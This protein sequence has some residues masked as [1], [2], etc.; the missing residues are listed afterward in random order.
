MRDVNPP[1]DHS[2]IATA[3][4]LVAALLALAAVAYEYSLLKDLRALTDSKAAALAHSQETL[5][6]LD[7]ELQSGARQ[8]AATAQRTR[9]KQAAPNNRQAGAARARPSDRA[10]D[11]AREDAQLLL[12]SDPSIR[13]T[14]EKIAR[15]QYQAL[16][17]AFI[18]QQNLTAQQTDQL[19]NAAVET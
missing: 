14:V 8:L 7:H 9:E 15:I 5:R 16:F 1:A 17:G 13:A 3:G 2:G 6:S 10:L 19:M 11:K 12:A 18:R 4:A